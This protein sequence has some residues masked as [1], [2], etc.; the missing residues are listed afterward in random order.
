M[1]YFL[2]VQNILQNIFMRKRR[3]IGLAGFDYT[4]NRYY[5]FTVF[6]KGHNREMGIL[7]YNNGTGQ[8][9]NIRILI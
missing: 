7:H 9:D 1:I 2:I 6:V 4:S 5:F 8:E 3:L